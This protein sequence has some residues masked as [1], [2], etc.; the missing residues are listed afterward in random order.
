MDALLQELPNKD[1]IE[2]GHWT[3][4]ANIIHNNETIETFL[5]KLEQNKANNYN[6]TLL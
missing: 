1:R 6:P 3:T 5:S 4:L 2:W